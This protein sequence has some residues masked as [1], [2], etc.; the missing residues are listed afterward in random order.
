MCPVPKNQKAL[1][2][3]QDTQ[4]SGWVHP[5]AE[6]WA[7][8]WRG[9]WARAFAVFPHEGTGRAVQAGLGLA[10]WGDFNRLWGSEAIPSCLV[11]GLG[12]IRAGKK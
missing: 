1:S 9:R 4:G 12:V 8:G 2:C 3:R 7:W 5:E 11:P 6:G 10:S